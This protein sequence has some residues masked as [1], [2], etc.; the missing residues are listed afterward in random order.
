MSDP[1]RDAAIAKARKIFE[2]RYSMDR[3]E[4]IEAGRVRDFCM[5]MNE[6]VPAAGKPVPPLF[7]LT[8]GRFR[9]PVQEKGAG[10]VNAGDDFRFFKPV[11]VGDIIESRRELL[12]I[13]EKQGKVG[14]MYLTRIETKYVNQHGEVVAIQRHN[15]LRWGL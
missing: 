13:D 4:V 2:A 6:P 1:N 5:A 10:A 11:Y 12:G 14:P 7:V 15:Q 9:R 8:L 3:K